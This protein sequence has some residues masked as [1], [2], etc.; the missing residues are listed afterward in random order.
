[1]SMNRKHRRAMGLGATGTHSRGKIHES[2][3][4]DLRIAI[5]AKD[6]VVVVDFGKQIA[7]IGFEP[8]RAEQFAQLILTRAAEIRK[9]AH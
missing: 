8:D 9:G 7:W 5:G 6:G 1:M 4:G 3:E 2:D